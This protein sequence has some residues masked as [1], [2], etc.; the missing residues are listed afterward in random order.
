MNRVFQD[1]LDKYVIVFI[2]DI[3]VYSKSE[4]EHADHLRFVLQ[5]LW[6]K[7]MYAKFSKC[8]FWLQQVAFL[9]HLVSAKGIEVD[10]GKVQSIVNW[11]TPK[12]VADIRSFL[13]LASY[14]RRFIENFSKISTRMT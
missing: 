6:E 4:E 5:R 7:Q 12:N 10:P 2:D 1:V 11:E 9:G 13:G 3:L 8:E 14:Y